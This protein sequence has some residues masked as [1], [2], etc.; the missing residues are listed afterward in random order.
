MLVVLNVFRT[1]VRI[2]TMHGFWGDSDPM[3]YTI[4]DYERSLKDFAV[5][6]AA[7]FITSLA[8]LRMIYAK[9]QDIIKALRRMNK[10]D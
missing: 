3:N 2:L 10:N 6:L 7:D 8:I 1:V 4:E 5:S 9:N